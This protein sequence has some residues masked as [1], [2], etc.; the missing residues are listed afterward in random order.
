MFYSKSAAAPKLPKQKSRLTNPSSKNQIKNPGGIPEKLSAAPLPVYLPV[1]AA[2]G[3]VVVG[4]VV[5]HVVVTN[6]VVP[7]VVVSSV[8]VGCIVVAHVVVRCVVI[9]YVVISGV[10]VRQ[11]VIGSIVVGNVVV[12]G[13]IVVSCTTAT[14]STNRAYGSQNHCENQQDSH[15]L[16]V[17]IKHLTDTIFSDNPI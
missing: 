10:V 4:V 13:I 11:I 14:H 5:C 3:C 2:G 15:N 1:A 16:P 9:T 17:H 6:V 8:I 7:C 12:S